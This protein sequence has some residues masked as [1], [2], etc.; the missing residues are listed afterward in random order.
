[1]ALGRP[2]MPSQKTCTFEGCEKRHE[3]KGLC[4]GHYRQ[5]MKGKPLVALRTTREPS[6]FKT[7]CA[8]KRTLSLAE[9]GRCSRARDGFRYNCK[10]CQSEAVRRKKYGLTPEIWGLIF[11]Q[12]GRRCRICG[13]AEPGGRGWS[14]DHDHGCCPGKNTCGQC[15]RGI[16]CHRCNVH[17]GVYESVDHNAF[18]RYLADPIYWLSDAEEASAAEFYGWDTEGAAT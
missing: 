14:T 4:P 9:F 6:D 11:D 2:T 7:C 3:A 15:V 17:L 1:M 16:L 5:S 8:C 18:D 10:R 12:Q 13:V